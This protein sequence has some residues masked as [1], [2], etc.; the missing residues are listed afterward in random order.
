MGRHGDD[1]LDGLANHADPDWRPDAR[2]EHALDDEAC[3]QFG[4]HPER[5]VGVTREPHQLPVRESDAR[6]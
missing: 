2:D 1:D 3:D 5:W 6:D 4:E